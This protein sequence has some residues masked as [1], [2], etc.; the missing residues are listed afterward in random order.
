[1]ISI[2]P[3]FSI[4]ASSL[5]LWT[6]LSQANS[7]FLVPKLAWLI[8]VDLRV[9]S[10]MPTSCKSYPW[11]GET[12][13][14]P[15]CIAGF[16]LALE[17]FLSSSTR[18]PNDLHGIFCMI[19]SLLHDFIHS[20]ESSAWSLAFA[21]KVVV[22]LASDN[23]RH[24]NDADPNC[25][26]GIFRL[27]PSLCHQGWSSIGIWHTQRCYAI[28]LTS[29]GINVFLNR[30]SKWINWYLHFSISKFFSQYV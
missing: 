17:L 14:L 1:M 4:S 12:P 26:G 22:Q 29:N 11:L 27:I 6:F 5:I 7:T 16:S 2:H 8:L 23:T 24:G 18:D 25:L 15:P 21:T 3:N 30:I 13:P 20:V 10:S 19:S 9:S 28:N